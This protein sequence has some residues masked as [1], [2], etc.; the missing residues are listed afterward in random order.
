M[1]RNLHRENEMQKNAIVVMQEN[2]VVIHRFCTG[3]EARAIL[4]AADTRGQAASAFFYEADDSQLI[5]DISP[6]LKNRVEKAKAQVRR[7][8]KMIAAMDKHGVPD[9]PTIRKAVFM[10]MYEVQDSMILLH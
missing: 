8:L 1:V 4:D 3:A 7:D 2:G 5:Y 6:D 9:D 10:A